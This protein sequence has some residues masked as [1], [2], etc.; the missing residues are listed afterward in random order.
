VKKKS[1]HGPEARARSSP[2]PEAGPENGSDWPVTGN[3]P[4]EEATKA[5]MENPNKVVE[6]E[7]LEENL[8]ATESEK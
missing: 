7:L 2:D 3:G 4:S 6:P 8:K 1:G 5:Y